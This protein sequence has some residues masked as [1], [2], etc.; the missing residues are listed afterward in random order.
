[1]FVDPTFFYLGNEVTLECFVAL[2]GKVHLFSFLFCN[3]LVN[4]TQVLEPLW[5]VTLHLKDAV[6]VDRKLITSKSLHYLRQ[7]L[8]FAMKYAC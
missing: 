8:P 6:V 4:S 5:A 2:W 7:V 1:M 3:G